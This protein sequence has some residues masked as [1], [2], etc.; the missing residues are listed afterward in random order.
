MHELN[1]AQTHTLFRWYGLLKSWIWKLAGF[2]SFHW[3]IPCLHCST[4]F[5]FIFIFLCHLQGTLGIYVCNSYRALWL[6]YQKLHC[7][8]MRLSPSFRFTKGLAINH[9]YTQELVGTSVIWNSVMYHNSPKLFT[10]SI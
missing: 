6:I 2:S 1:L 7:I 3:T 8:T 10:N 9:G 5:C 4:V